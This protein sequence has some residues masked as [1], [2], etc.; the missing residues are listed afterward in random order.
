[1]ETIRPHDE[2]IIGG[3]HRKEPHTVHLHADSLVEQRNRRTHGGLKLDNLLA[4]SISG[5]DGLVIHDHR[6]R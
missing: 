3:F 1:M 2:Q 5:V 6:K 4:G